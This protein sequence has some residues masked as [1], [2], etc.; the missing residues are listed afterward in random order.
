M[1]GQGEDTLHIISA[2][3]EYRTS[4]AALIN[5]IETLH[6][7]QNSDFGIRI[8]ASRF[9]DKIKH[10]V[11]DGDSASEGSV[12]IGALAAGTGLPIT[13]KP[14]TNRARHPATPEEIFSVVLY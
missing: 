8:D 1:G 10:L 9:D 2:V 12:V 14:A 7:T 4:D 11:V 13:L 6:V 5:N 3:N